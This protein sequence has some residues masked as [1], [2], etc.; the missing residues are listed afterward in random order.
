MGLQI[1]AEF[2]TNFHRKDRK[3]AIFFVQ[4]GDFTFL[5]KDYFFSFRW[6][7]KNIFLR[8]PLFIPS[9]RIFPLGKKVPRVGIT[10]ISEF[11]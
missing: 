7:Q 11:L 6:A 5:E 9:S 8:S 4:L 2:A 1:W 3:E 10:A